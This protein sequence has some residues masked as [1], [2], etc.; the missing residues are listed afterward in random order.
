MPTGRAEGHLGPA[1]PGKYP[2]APSLWLLRPSVCL[3]PGCGFVSWN[4][5]SKGLI[6]AADAVDVAGVQGASVSLGAEELGDPD[7]WPVCEPVCLLAGALARGVPCRQQGHP[8]VRV[9][10][11]PLARVNTQISVKENQFL[12]FDFLTTSRLEKSMLMISPTDLEERSRCNV[13]GFL[14]RRKN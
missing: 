12:V 3:S 7:G 13:L 1:Q 10:N 11:A 14:G 2:I 4:L 9:A 5:D 8:L 6:S